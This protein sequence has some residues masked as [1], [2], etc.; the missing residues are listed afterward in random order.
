MDVIR[1]LTGAV[2]F[3]TRLPVGH[4]MA[5]W[6]AFYQRPWTMVVVGY[7]IG[8]IAGL[9]FVPSLPAVTTAVLFPVVL[10]GLI[11]I[12]HLDGTADLGDA[13]VI[14]GT[15]SDRRAVL[16]DTEVGVG[17]TVAV[18]IVILGLGTAGLSIAGLPTSTAVGIVIAA[19]VTAKLAMAGLACLG[20]AFGD[21]LGRAVTD[22]LAPKDTAAPIVCAVPM[23][24]LVSPTVAIAV[25]LSGL[26]IA[27]AVLWWAK[28]NLGGING[29]CFGATN[30]LAR[31]V[32][33][34]MGVIVWTL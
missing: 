2:G 8:L 19:E 15:L 32:G 5:Q 13:A 1:G 7:A 20:T 22:G 30:E 17:G 14:H 4:T 23:F 25:V 28:R 21:G 29:D 34:H 16:K 33:L 31:V 11:G 18:I 24:A 3:L 12:A 6:E 27:C 26:V 10:I 9:V